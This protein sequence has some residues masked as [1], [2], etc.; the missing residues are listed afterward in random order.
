MQTQLFKNVPDFTKLVDP[1][2]FDNA[3]AAARELVAINS[4]L[5][6]R[7]LENQ[8][9]L[10]NL[11]VEGGEKQMRTVGNINNPQDF[12]DKQVALYEEYREKITAVAGNNVKLAQDTGEEYVAWFKRNLPKTETLKPKAV[13]ATKATSAKAAVN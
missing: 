13:K 12:T 7:Y 2:I 4:R 3:M 11:C 6:E 9:G 5:L 8:I 1:E 10:A